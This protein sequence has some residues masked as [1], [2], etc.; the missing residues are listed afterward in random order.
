MCR[1]L[2]LFSYAA[3][4]WTAQAATINFTPIPGDATALH[5]NNMGVSSG[6]LFDANGPHGYIRDVNGTFTLFNAPGLFTE[7]VNVDNSGVVY[8]NAFTSMTTTQIFRRDTSGNFTLLPPILGAADSEGGNTNAAG[9]LVGSADAQGFIMPAGGQAVALDFPGAAITGASGINDAGYVV[10]FSR[11]SASALPQGFIRDPSGNFTVYNAPGALATVVYS[12]NNAGDLA[13]TYL[14]L[15]SH[16][17]G[18]LYRSATG[19]FS[20]VDYKLQD[21]TI[22]SINDH[23]QLAGASYND[24]QFAT[25]PFAG[26]LGTEV[27]EPAAG[28]LAGLGLAAFGVRRSI[29]TFLYRTSRQI[30]NPRQKAAPQKNRAESWPSV[31]LRKWG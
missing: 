4:A 18:F 23:L 1:F 31:G 3:L 7:A 9:T 30:S 26:F 14:G 2:P 19:V 8:G 15:D 13:G 22:F 25:G 10:G 6:F 5:I 16:F 11:T 28:L 12:I 17:H 21:T 20:T 27:P 24:G 29:N